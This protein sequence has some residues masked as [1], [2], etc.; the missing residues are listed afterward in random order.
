MRGRNIPERSRALAQADIQ[1]DTN[2]N[3]L[4]VGVLDMKEATPHG[5]GEGIYG[6]D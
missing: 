5:E 3:A 6:N 2:S 4:V 1:G